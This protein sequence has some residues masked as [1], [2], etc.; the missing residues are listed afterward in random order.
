LQQESRGCQIPRKPTHSVFTLPVGRA[1]SP[2]KPSDRACFSPATLLSF[3]PSRSYAVR[4]SSDV[5]VTPPPLPFLVTQGDA[6][7]FGGF[8]PSQSGIAKQACYPYPLGL[9]P[10]EALPL[11]AVASVSRSI[12]SALRSNQA[13]AQST[14]APQS[15]DKR[16]VGF[17]PVTRRSRAAPAPLG[18][19]TSSQPALESPS[20]VSV[21]GLKTSH[22]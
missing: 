14:A 3:A 16:R 21:T 19:V 5:S 4:R 1:H 18:F 17:I 22:E 10:S 2:S 12:L 7:D 20:C 8:G 9:F 6:L 15:I 13:K 11:T